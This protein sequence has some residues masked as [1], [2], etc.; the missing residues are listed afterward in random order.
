MAVR[1]D[2]VTLLPFSGHGQLA[3][4]FHGMSAKLWIPSKPSC[5]ALCYW[6]NLFPSQRS[7]QVT[8]L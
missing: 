7:L 8:A 1:A 2:M 6:G 3:A 5:I 4:L